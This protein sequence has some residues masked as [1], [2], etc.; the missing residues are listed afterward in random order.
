MAFPHDG[1]KFKKGESGNLKGRPPIPSLK[2]VLKNLIDSHAP[3]SIIDLTYVQKLTERKDLTY[4]DVLALRLT[5]AALVEGDIA[6][7]REIFDRL[8]GKAQQ[9]IEHTGQMTEIIISK[10]V[11]TKKS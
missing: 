2:T 3:K 8:E 4:N 7:I 5:T 11:L 10:T 6:A 9:S 1:K